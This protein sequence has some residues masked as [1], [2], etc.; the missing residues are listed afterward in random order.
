[1]RKQDK[2]SQLFMCV[3]IKE[4]DNIKHALPNLIK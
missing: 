2:N 3:C 1:M 4:N